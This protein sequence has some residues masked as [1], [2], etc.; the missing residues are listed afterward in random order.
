MEIIY[1]QSLWVSNG[2]GAE[3]RLEV[4]R[5]DGKVAIWDTY[6][7]NFPNGHLLSLK[8]SGTP[9]RKA[10]LKKWD[11]LEEFLDGQEVVK[12]DW[13]GNLEYAETKEK[14]LRIIEAMPPSIKKLVDNK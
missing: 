2:Y 10:E 3:L 8:R 11:S 14:K 7:A 12:A 13:M 9:E 1:G 4:E 5:A 6:S